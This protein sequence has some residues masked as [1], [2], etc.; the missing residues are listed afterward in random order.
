[1][2]QHTQFSHH[3]LLRGQHPI[4]L[5]KDE[6]KTSVPTPPQLPAFFLVLALL[7]PVTRAI[8]KEDCGVDGWKDGCL[9]GCDV[10]ENK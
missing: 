1:M 7:P 8:L 9:H 10:R 4:T 3:H 6:G 5:P 2:K